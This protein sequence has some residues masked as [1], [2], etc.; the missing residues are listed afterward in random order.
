MAVYN[1]SYD[2]VKAGQDY[3]GLIK[4]LKNSDSWWHYLGS[5]WL[6]AT[7]ETALQLITRLKPY[8]DDN[9]NILI[10]EVVNSKA[11]WLPQEAWDWINQYVTRY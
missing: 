5:T 2:L 11:G 9:D 6:I 4:E 7:N 10:I 3:D 8:I 1:V